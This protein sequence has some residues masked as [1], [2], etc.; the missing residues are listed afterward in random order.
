MKV[1]IQTHPYP[2]SSQNKC[3]EGGI[4]PGCQKYNCAVLNKAVLIMEIDLVGKT[5]NLKQAPW[6][7]GTVLLMFAVLN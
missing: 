6:V 1:K 7:P 2:K 5:W 4:S 3:R